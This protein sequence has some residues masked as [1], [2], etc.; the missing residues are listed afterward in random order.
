[1][2]LVNSKNPILDK[3]V[4]KADYIS[5]FGGCVCHYSSVDTEYK[6]YPT[7]QCQCKT[8]NVANDN[9]NDYSADKN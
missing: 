6:G 4:T 5:T 8:G 9:L 1:M 7:C 3:L 2:K